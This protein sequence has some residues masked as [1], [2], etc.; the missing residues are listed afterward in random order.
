MGLKL[1]IDPNKWKL[2][3]EVKL[4]Q[5]NAYWCKKTDGRIV[6][7]AP[8]N[9]GSSYGMAQCSIT[10]KGLAIVPGKFWILK[11]AL[12]QPVEFED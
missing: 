12:V 3:T 11:N 1:V 8:H 5:N 2:I 4:I 7:A 10:R 9:N 6:M